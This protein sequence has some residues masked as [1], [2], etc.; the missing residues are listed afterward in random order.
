MLVGR[1]RQGGM[2]IGADMSGCGLSSARRTT[3]VQASGTIWWRNR[4]GR[5]G[6]GKFG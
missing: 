3:R 1:L 5:V 6:F 4:N 2:G